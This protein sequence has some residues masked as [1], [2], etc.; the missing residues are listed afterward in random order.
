MTSIVVAVDGSEASLKGV[1]QAV[2]LAQ[3]MGA[4]LELAYVSAP[5]LLPPSVYGDTIKAIDASEDQHAEQVLNAAAKVAGVE[6]KKVHLK[7]PPAESISDY[8]KA[9]RVW[10]IVVGAKGHNALSRMMLG[11]TA[12]RLVHVS[13]KPVLVVR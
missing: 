3:G 5:V 10:A 7:G 2:D 1:R 12:D 11:S 4:S 9:D 8:A 13:L 6:C